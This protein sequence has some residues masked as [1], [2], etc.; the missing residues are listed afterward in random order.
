M[1]KLT[2]VLLNMENQL[3]L[4]TKFKNNAVEAIYIL[5]LVEEKHNSLQLY[6]IKQFWA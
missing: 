5:H 2:K 4:Q 6:F 1:N 3:E